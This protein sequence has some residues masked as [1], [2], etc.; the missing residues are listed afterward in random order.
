MFQRLGKWSLDWLQRSTPWS[1]VYGAARSLIA[2]AHLLTFTA[3]SSTTLFHPILGVLET[4]QGEG[5]TRYG[6]FYLLRG[7]LD[8]ARWLASIVLLLVVIGWRPRWTGLLHA[9]LAW[10]FDHNGSMIEGGEQVAQIL[11]ML[12]IPVTLTDSR[13]WHW[14]PS[15]MV[16]IDGNAAILRKMV[17]SI[18]LVA[19][20]LQ[21]CGIYLHASTGKFTVQA[22]ADGTAMYYF[23][24]NHTFGPAP[25]LRPF[26]LWLCDH[27]ALLTSMTWGAMLIEVAL[28]ASLL[29]D[30]RWWTPFLL[31][32]VF[33]HTGIALI[34]G[35]ISFALIMI[36]AVVLYLRPKERPFTVPR[37][38]VLRFRK[39][40]TAIPFVLKR[41]VPT[42]QT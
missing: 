39:Y 22:W 14:G 3:C 32:G 42:L 8:L 23:V 38:I 11:T 26:A 18:F 30:K 33:L 7:H 1:N 6:F 9:Y 5:I 20:R 27:G 15:L 4:P 41:R 31:A 25:W 35:L 29:A 28:A 34:H 17:A 21:V 36:G 2:L 19:I 10:S 24:S 12:M 16:P 37:A 40:F 13:K